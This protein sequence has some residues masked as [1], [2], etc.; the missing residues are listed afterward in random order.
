MGKYETRFKL[1]V[2]ESCLAGEGGAKL[3]APRSSER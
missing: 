2:V 1:K 3:V